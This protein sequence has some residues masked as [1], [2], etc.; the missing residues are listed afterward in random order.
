MQLKHQLSQ[1]IKT[2]QETADKNLAGGDEQNLKCD[3][4]ILYQF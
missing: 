1:A 2:D 3:Q 4:R